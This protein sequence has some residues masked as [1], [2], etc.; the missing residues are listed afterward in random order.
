MHMSDWQVNTYRTFIQKL[1]RPQNYIYFADRESYNEYVQYDKILFDKIFNKP[2]QFLDFSSKNA[3]KDQLI[4]KH[5]LFFLHYCICA[6]GLFKYYLGSV[7][8]P[9]NTMFKTCI[10]FGRTMYAV[11][12]ICIYQLIG[13]HD[14]VGTSMVRY[15]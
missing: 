5:D 8:R 12:C 11:P 14:L 1:T 15:S 13:K 3:P 7:H 6:F 4:G 10:Y 9:Q 2:Y